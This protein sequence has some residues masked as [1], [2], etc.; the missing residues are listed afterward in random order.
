MRRVPSQ[1]HQGRSGSFAPLAQ[2]EHDHEHGHE[3]ETE[4][5]AGEEGQ[6]G[7]HRLSAKAR[8][9]QQVQQVIRQSSLTHEDQQYES[10]PNHHEYAASLASSR[11]VRGSWNSPPE[12]FQEINIAELAG[13]YVEYYGPRAPSSLSK[14]SDVPTESTFVDDKDKFFYCAYETP[15]VGIDEKRVSPTTNRP[16]R[17]FADYR[18]F[19]LK[20]SFSLV[21]LLLLGV[22]L[23]LTVYS[24]QV[25]PA[26]DQLL[27]SPNSPSS[28]NDTVPGLRLRGLV[29][30]RS[31]GLASLISVKVGR[32]DQSGNVTQPGQAQPDEGQPQ[33]SSK[34]APVATPPVDSTSA[35]T[36]PTPGRGPATTD[37]ADPTTPP[38]QDPSP[39]KPEPGDAKPSRSLPGKQP[40]PPQTS[41]DNQPTPTNGDGG[42][43]QIP[44]TSPTT[45]DPPKESPPKPTTTDKPPTTEATPPK[46]APSPTGATPPTEAPSPTEAPL[47]TETPS[48]TETPGD[49]GTLLPH[50]QPGDQSPGTVIRSLL[51]AVKRPRN[52]KIQALHFKLRPQ[53][54]ITQA[55]NVHRSPLLGTVNPRI[56]QIPQFQPQ[57]QIQAQIQTQIQTQIQ[58]LRRS[59]AIN[60]HQSLLPT[61][62]LTI[63]QIP[64]FKPQPQLQTLRRSQ[65]NNLHQSLLPDLTI[66]Q[67]PQLQPQSQIQALRRSRAINFHQSLLPATRLRI[68]QTLQFKPQDQHPIQTL[69]SKSHHLDRTLQFKLQPLIQNL[70]LKLQPLIRTH[71]FGFQHLIQNLRP[72]SPPASSMPPIDQSPPPPPPRPS[73][74]PPVDQ[75]PRPGNTLALQKQPTPPP[76]ASI[77]SSA[78]LLLLA[79]SQ[80]DEVPPPVL[81]VVSTPLPDTDSPPPPPQQQKPEI[82]LPAPQPDNPENTPPPEQKEPEDGPLRPLHTP[83]PQLKK[84]ENTPVPPH[85]I[86]VVVATKV[87]QHSTMTSTSTETTTDPVGAIFTQ[88]RITTLD[89]VQKVVSQ[90]TIVYTD[91]TET[92]NFMTWIY[93]TLTDTAGSPTATQSRLVNMAPFLRT[94]TDAE[95]RPTST[96]TAWH[97]N[98]WRVRTKTNGRGGY[99]TETYASKTTT[100]IMVDAFGRATATTTEILTET[101]AITTLYDPN[102]VPTKTKTMWEPVTST[103]LMIVTPTVA[104]NSSHDSLTS[105]NMAGLN[106][107]SKDYF[108]GLV[109]PPFL[110]VAVSVPVRILDQTAKLYQPFH[111]LT[112]KHGAETVDSLCLQ[113]S[114]LLGFVTGV[115]SLMR[116][117]VLLSVTGLLLL[118]NAVL[119]PLSA[120]AFRISVQGPDCS[121][122]TAASSDCNVV[123]QA[124]PTLVSIA[125]ALLSIM[126]LLAI[127][128]AITLRKWKTGVWKNPW[129]MEVM[130]LLATN[131]KFCALIKRLKPKNS[132]VIT[133]KDAIK[134]FGQRRFGLK[135]WYDTYGWEYGIV[136][137]ND[138]GS[139][140]KSKK[141]SVGFSKKNLGRRSKAMPFYVLSIW[142]RLL[143]LLL[144]V[145]LLITSLVYISTG[146]NSKFDHFMD[147]DSL[148]VRFLFC[149]VGVVVSLFWATFFN[150]VAF[151][152]P[153]RLY[154]KCYDIA[155]VL[156]PPTN[157]YSGLW[158]VC[159]WRRPEG[160]LGLVAFTAILS[161]VLPILLANVPSK[162]LQASTAH[163]VCTWFAAAILSQMLVVIT[164]SFLVDWPPMSMDPST[165]AGAMYFALDPGT[166]MGCYTTRSSTPGGRS[167][168]V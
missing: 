14:Q 50:P 47:P 137:E 150:A 31:F 74:T 114:S 148:G 5:E 152:S 106:L 86:T 77:T 28:H 57:T 136:V 112:I 124:S 66:N 22:L 138:A 145:A 110:A 95:G 62:H 115:Q 162:D 18:P 37:V 80:P 159:K 32:A 90:A 40:Q 129:S 134:A 93:T 166:F 117:H 36:L 160:Y 49:S 65:A 34:P 82:T 109:L 127:V 88:E 163:L 119:I 6:L 68:I 11:L 153:Y 26:E 33:E 56:N 72:N 38:M 19:V 7:G 87:D 98:Q 39:P 29:S 71:Q 69:Q 168:Q 3:H 64:Q 12:E 89:L 61:I 158:E 111:A 105:A 142:G 51:P 133:N 59:R 143:A 154:R 164:W 165:V 92:G 146:A 107:S 144:L 16:M 91:W 157:A 1:H 121:P 123:L 116:H 24:T 44:P 141:R 147:G 85:T 97:Q 155:P 122:R 23:G 8:F 83:P 63:N 46:E 4:V 96:G 48:P 21:L 139:L 103:S 81:G 70:R 2:D 78:T 149:G 43:V 125:I 126:M 104:S 128:S 75:T 102:G 15:I 151:L 131:E 84:P 108:V 60:F 42:G 53:L 13:T 135:G 54:Q 9:Q 20:S 73:A 161:D 118:I 76:A 113:S 156:T 140:L 120:E 10:V 132:G 100:S 25:L 55:M 27:G 30:G 94:Y 79:T 58:I 35:Q 45:S 41:P 99:T 167:S 67:I 17:N 101:L 130:G 52:L